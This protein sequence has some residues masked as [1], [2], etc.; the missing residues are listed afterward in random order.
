MCI[1]KTFLLKPNSKTQ[2]PDRLQHDRPAACVIAQ[3]YSSANSVSLRFHYPKE[4]FKQC[5]FNFFAP[6]QFRRYGDSLRAG[7]SDD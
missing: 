7:P 4:Y 3:Q 5:V 6:G 1:Y 2:E